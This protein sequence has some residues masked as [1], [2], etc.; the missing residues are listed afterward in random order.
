MIKNKKFPIKLKSD[1]YIIGAGG[2][3]YSCIDVILS[4]GYK[5]KGI[6]GLKKDIGKNI[7]GYKVRGTQFEL[8][9]TIKKNDNLHIAVGHTFLKN[10]K[11][12]I[13]KLFKGKCKFPKII[14][15]FS[16]VSPHSNIEAGTIVMHGAK[17]GVESYIGEHSIINTNSS[18]DHN[19]KVGNFSHISTSVT[20]NGNVEIGNNVF[21]GSGT[22]VKDSIKISSNQ[23]IKMCSRIIKDK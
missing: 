10:E 19:S 9:N 12:K 15:P 1:I 14:S 16:I 13:L 21:I 5:I 23:S 20:L 6:Y 8:S 18:I 22:V 3:A 2:H 17:V 7:L 11:H 4:C